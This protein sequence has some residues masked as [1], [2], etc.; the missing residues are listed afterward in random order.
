V[1]WLLVAACWLISFLFAGIEAGLLALD[2]VRLRHRAKSGERTA[3]RLEKM[4]THPERLLITVLLATNAADIIALIILTHRLEQAF[5]ARG[6]FIAVAVALPVYLF[7]LGVLP[8]SL[9]RRFPLRA[10]IRLS[11]LLEFVTIVLRP[12]LAVG[13]KI[14]RILFSRTKNPPRLFT[15]REELK[16]IA[17]QSERGGALSSAERAMVHNVVDFTSVA[18]G[19]VMVPVKKTVALQIDDSTEKV[20]RLSEETGI[21]RFPVLE[22]A[23]AIGLINVFDLLVDTARPVNLRNYMRRIITAPETESAYRLIRRLRAARIGL[24]AIVDARG[25]FSGIVALE[26]LV[27]QL[28]RG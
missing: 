12:L 11:G 23:K 26:D 17:V 21:D 19:A 14:V 18:V 24:A 6:Y 9:F 28:V 8:K 2:P 3:Q 20:L 1:I 22:N 25:K 10:L 27:R 4:L 16:S 15:G 5:G 13:E 7:L